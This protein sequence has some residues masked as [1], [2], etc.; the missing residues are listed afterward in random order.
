MP[1]RRVLPDDTSQKALP[2][3][4]PERAP[5]TEKASAP[6]QT[7]NIDDLAASPWVGLHYRHEFL[8]HH[9]HELLEQHKD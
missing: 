3:G 7:V 6:R 5:L 8:L 9:R 1:R 2:S 4:G